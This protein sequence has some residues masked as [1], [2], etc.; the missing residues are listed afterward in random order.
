LCSSGQPLDPEARALFERRFGHDFSQVHT[1]EKAAQAV[2]DLPSCQKISNSSG[3]IIKSYQLSTFE[4][5]IYAGV[6]YKCSSGFKIFKSEQWG[7]ETLTR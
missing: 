5:H 7:D 4:T 1:K 3:H 2:N 6:H